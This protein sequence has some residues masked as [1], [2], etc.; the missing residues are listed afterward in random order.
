MPMNDLVLDL[1]SHEEEAK[2]SSSAGS[3]SAPLR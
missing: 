2:P 1:R 3:I